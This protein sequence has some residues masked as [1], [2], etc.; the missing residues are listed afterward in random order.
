MN[1]AWFGFAN[2][3]VSSFTSPSNRISEVH[4]SK[5]KHIRLICITAGVAALIT[6]VSALPASA[7][8]TSV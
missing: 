3:I 2:A 8:G 7:I 4:M 6:I 1:L 5:L